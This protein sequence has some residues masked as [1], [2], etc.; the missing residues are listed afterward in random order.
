LRFVEVVSGAKL[1]R[2]ASAVEI[3]AAMFDRRLP[4]RL[5]DRAGDVDH[6]NGDALAHVLRDEIGQH[7]LHLRS[8]LWAVSAA[9]RRGY[10]AWSFVPKPEDA[11]N[12][13][14]LGFRIGRVDRSSCPWIAVQTSA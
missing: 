14:T 2:S 6:D 9:G 1:V 10:G 3:A 5:L 4:H 8:R 13:K 12:A 7:L 11:V